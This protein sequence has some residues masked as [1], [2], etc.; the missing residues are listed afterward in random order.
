MLPNNRH[1]EEDIHPDMSKTSELALPSQGPKKR[2]GYHF[3]LGLRTPSCL[4]E[5]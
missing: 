1:H 4:V 3:R 2:A 5:G